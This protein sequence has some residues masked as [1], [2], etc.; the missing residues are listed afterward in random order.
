MNQNPLRFIDPTGENS[1]AFF[2]IAVG[3]Y[4]TYTKLE[5]CALCVENNCSNSEGENEGD[6]RQYTQ[7]R[8]NCSLDNFFGSTKEKQGPRT[9]L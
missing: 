6:T 4:T 9:K 2:L 8:R 3:G 5:D 1:L 7:C